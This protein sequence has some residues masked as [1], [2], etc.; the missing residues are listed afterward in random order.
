MLNKA[1]GGQSLKKIYV[2][3]LKFGAYYSID[4]V[5]VTDACREGYN[6]NEIRSYTTVAFIE[7]EGRPTCM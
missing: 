5:T 6:E 4:S 1:L 3:C 7:G 2:Q